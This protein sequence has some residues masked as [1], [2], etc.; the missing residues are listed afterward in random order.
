MLFLLPHKVV[1]HI[2]TPE[3]VWY[4]IVRIEFFVFATFCWRRLELVQ[5]GRALL[6]AV[7]GGGVR[8]GGVTG[9]GRQ[10]RHNTLRGTL[11]L[12]AD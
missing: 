9:A 10:N 4:C 8:G 1:G 11:P 5:R 6:F 12:S 2:R 3:S 7:G